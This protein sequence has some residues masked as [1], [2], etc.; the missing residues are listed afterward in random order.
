MTRKAKTLLKVGLP[1]VIVIQLI[2][3]T[4]LLARLNRDKAFSCKTAREYL[5]C[6]QVDSII[7]D[8]NTKKVFDKWA[9]R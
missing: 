3:I 4:F 7:K 2:S 8:I 1:L 9:F 5:V 6:R